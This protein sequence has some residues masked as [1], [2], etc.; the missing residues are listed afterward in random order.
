MFFSL[1]LICMRERGLVSEI[2][3]TVAVIGTPKDTWYSLACFHFV[4]T[5]LIF[6]MVLHKLQV[7]H[8]CEL[9]SNLPTQNKN[10]EFWHSIF[11]CSFNEGRNRIL[12]SFGRKGYLFGQPD[13]L[14]FELLCLFCAFVF[15]VVFTV[16]QCAQG[17]MWL[18]LKLCRCLGKT[19]SE[20]LL[21]KDIFNLITQQQ[22]C[23]EGFSNCGQR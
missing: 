4:S 1:I 12:N 6:S 11:I 14:W 9:K 3:E 7:Y 15:V 5:V 21:S 22:V 17:L 20:K 16:M 10:L 18:F 13:S 19:V 8:P 23:L 2:S